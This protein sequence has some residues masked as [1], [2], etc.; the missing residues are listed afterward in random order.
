M[1]EKCSFFIVIQI[2]QIVE[3]F[4]IRQDLTGKKPFIY[5]KNGRYVATR[6]CCL[7]STRVIVK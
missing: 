2:Q 5:S 7:A 1:F 6:I 3:F 4:L